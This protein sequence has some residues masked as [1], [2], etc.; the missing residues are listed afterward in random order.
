V[1]SSWWRPAAAGAVLV[2]ATVVSPAQARADAFPCGPGFEKRISGVPHRVQI[3]EERSGDGSIDVYASASMESGVVGHIAI[4]G[5]DWYECQLKG[6][7]ANLGGGE[8]I[9]DWWARTMAD[10]GRWGYVSELYFKGAESMRPDG[11]LRYC[12]GVP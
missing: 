7:M 6:G 1:G 3:C 4:A 12:E 8:L 10:D 9:N 11:G 2:A 5:D